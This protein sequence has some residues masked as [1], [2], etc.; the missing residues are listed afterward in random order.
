MKRVL[1]IMKIA[2]GLLIVLVLGL[3]FY[4]SSEQSAQIHE[5][6]GTNIPDAGPISARPPALTDPIPIVGPDGRV[7][8]TKTDHWRGKVVHL[9][10]WAQWCEPCRIELP[11]LEKEQKQRHGDY[12]AILINVDQDKAGRLVAAKL[13]EHEDPDLLRAFDKSGD[14]QN[15]YNVQALPLHVILDR[16]GRIAAMF[17]STIYGRPEFDR[18][19]GELVRER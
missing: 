18:L 11:L 1:T 14:L 17:A 8:E 9:I 4:N 15:D 19:I 12:R 16:E 5:I 7:H 10:F 6:P 13:A 3:I 2:A